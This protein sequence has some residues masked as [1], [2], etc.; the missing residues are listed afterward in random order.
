MQ[1]PHML[2]RPSPA[3]VIA[4]IAL[5]VA[6]GETSFAAVSRIFPQ[7][8]V[9]T[10]QLQDNSVTSAKVRNFS[11]RAW[12]F[13]QGELPRGPRGGPGPQGPAGVIGDLTMHATSVTVPGNV[14]P[15][16]RY[17]TKVAQVTCGPGERAI[18]GGTSWTDDNDDRELMTVYSRPV[19][20]AGKPTG[21]R[22]R[23]GSDVDADRVFTVE[24][25]C[26]KG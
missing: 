4:C 18:T 3:I 15:N 6:L 10:V 21:W 12:D 2:P 16:G 23:G 13:R 8:S 1:K 26:A 20:E 25:L 7:D 17:V 9:G 5:V 14:A 11:L 24:V 19:I 22:A